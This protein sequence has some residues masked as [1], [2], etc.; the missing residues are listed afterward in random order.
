MSLRSFA[1]SSFP[2]QKLLGKDLSQE[3]T[4]KRQIY[5]NAFAASS[6]QS[7]TSKFFS[8]RMSLL[9]SFLKKW[10]PLSVRGAS[11]YANYTM[12]KIE[13]ATGHVVVWNRKSLL[14]E[15]E[16][17]TMPAVRGRFGAA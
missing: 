14:Q 3:E 11:R 9:D 8:G 12:L 13:N 17:R 4:T 2:S 15:A 5:S 10:R 1:E 7:L 16:A 6:C